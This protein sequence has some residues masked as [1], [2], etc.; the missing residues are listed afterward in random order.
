VNSPFPFPYLEEQ[1]TLNLKAQATTQASVSPR[2]RKSLR[3]T[4]GWRSAKGKSSVINSS[5]ALTCKGRDSNA[6][7][8]R[9]ES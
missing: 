8:S 2:Q 4:E 7:G 3:K 1:L 5:A 9:A 6:G